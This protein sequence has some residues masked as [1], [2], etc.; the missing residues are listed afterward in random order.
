MKKALESL[1]YPKSKDEFIKLY[2]SNTPFVVHNLKESI[3]ELIEL[4]FLKSLQDLMSIW[5][6]EVEVHLPEISD[7]ASAVQVST[8]KAKKMHDSGMGL[9]FNDV[10]TISPLLTQWLDSLRLDM[11][12]SA[13]TYG[14]NLIYA[15]KAGKGTAPHFDQNI[16]FVIQVHGTKKWWI[17][18]NKNV[19]NPMTRHTMGLPI[20]NELASYAKAPMPLKMPESATEVTL[21]PGSMLFVPRGSWHCTEALTD[22]LAL[23][24]T[25]SAPTWIDLFS[26]ALRSRLALSPEW[27]QT[28][29]YVSD[30]KRSPEAIEKFNILLAELSYD[31]QNWKAED[32]L[33]ATEAASKKQT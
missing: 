7:E 6:E 14:R 33:G 19:V 12:L 27:R 25:F 24:F 26:A 15:T 28:A 5:K 1:I 23:N 32:I 20:D 16:N 8:D 30:Q 17:A 13:Q 29:N 3:S 10:N 2:E 18:A 22:A 9:L 11:G 4:P 31:A 21:K